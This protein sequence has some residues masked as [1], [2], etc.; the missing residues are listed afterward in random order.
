MRRALFLVLIAVCRGAGRSE[1]Q[2]L[3][4]FDAWVA[5]AMKDW[6]TPG[7][8][9]RRRQ[10]RPGGLRARVRRARARQAAAG[11]H[12]HAVRD[13]LDHQGDD[14][15]A[16]RHAGR[17]EEGRLGCAGHPVPAVVS[18]QGRGGDAR[19]ERARSA[20]APRRP[21]QR[22]LSLVR[23]APFDRRDPAARPADRSGVSGAFGLHLPEHHVCRGRGARSRRRRESRGPR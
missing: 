22:R 15:G 17:R 23:A 12:A 6:R 3:A 4:G 14:R 18:A 16:R 10:G 20:H 2:P 7:M 13:R 1:P 9:D 5:K 8:A 19:A 21:R 11:G